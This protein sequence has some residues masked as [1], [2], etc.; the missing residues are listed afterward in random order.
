LFTETDVVARKILL[1]K[2]LVVAC[3]GVWLGILAFGLWP[4]NFHPKNRVEWLPNRNGIHFEGYGE[5]Y[6]RSQWNRNVGA[7]PDQG[8]TVELRVSGEK[9]YRAVSGLVSLVDSSP[10]CFTIAQS[11]PDVLV[12][13]Q[14]QDKNHHVAIRRF[15]I[16][17]AFQQAQ[18]R[19][20]AVTSG[21][22]GTK[23]YL[24][25]A[26]Q[27]QFPVTLTTSN[28]VG[29]LLLGHNFAGHQHWSGDLLGLAIYDHALTGAQIS[30]DY[31]AWQQTNAAE[32][33]ERPG[34]S[35]LYLF[36]E[37]VGDVVHNKAGDAPDIIIPERFSLLHKTFLG[38]S[39][40]HRANLDLKDIVINIT[41][42]VPFG[43][44]L[45]AYLRWGKH[46]GAGRAILLTILL[47]ALTSLTIEL[48]QAYLPSRDSSLLD[49][50]DNALG[51]FLGSV[52]QC[53]VAS[54]VSPKRKPAI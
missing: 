21:P 18:V 25:G 9:R 4:F 34:V 13:G 23:L 40:L 14:F 39:D 7:D 48:L 27:R 19:L 5:A 8:F 53:G 11:G 47:G 44:F 43:F 35:A 24:D 50:I 52:I 16:D 37:R 33:I 29:R 1:G 12:R 49:V 51:T 15:Y 10:E 2:L 41:G 32:L 30:E 31:S 17:D 54:V 26:P 36:D 6:S 28:L 20:I 42:F 3:L 46:A 38:T 45:C 22:Q